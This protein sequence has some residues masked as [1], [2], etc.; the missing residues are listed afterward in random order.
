MKKLS[1]FLTMILVSYFG[2]SQNWQE[3]NKY[4]GDM[5]FYEIQK[6]FNQFEKSGKTENARAVY[7]SVEKVPVIPDGKTILRQSKP[8]KF[9][10][11]RLM[12]PICTTKR[13]LS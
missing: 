6:S 1:L 8:A 13:P 10:L 4:A 5:N 9:Q 3:R 7:I 11:I 12:R 2:Y